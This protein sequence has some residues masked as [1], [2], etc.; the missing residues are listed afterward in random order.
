SVV[1]LT[2]VLGALAGAY[3][4]LVLSAFSPAVVLKSGKLPPS[5]SGRVRQALVMLQFA[6]LIG[7]IV[8]TA[9]VYRQV[10]YANNEGLRLD[11]DQ[12]LLV[13]TSCSHALRDQ[14]AALP[15]VRAAACSQSH[16]LNFVE[17]N[18]P[19]NLE[20]GTRVFLTS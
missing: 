7:L 5:G 17:G 16:A 9:V 2:V 6:I 4:A 1:G 14:V 12:V 10:Q 8:S 19:F 15:G 11:T 20:D 13:A 18:Y 3:P